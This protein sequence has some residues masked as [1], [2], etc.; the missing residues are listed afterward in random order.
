LSNQNETL[1]KIKQQWIDE[2]AKLH[3]ILLSRSKELQ[4]ERDY[5]TKEKNELLTIIEEKTKIIEELTALLNRSK[6]NIF[7]K[8]AR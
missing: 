2:T 4:I 8:F 7:Q 1:I 6:M 3:E 5:F